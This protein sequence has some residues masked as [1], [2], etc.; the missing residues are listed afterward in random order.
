VRD[1]IDSLCADPPP[2]VP[3]LGPAGA[4]KST[5]TLKALHDRRV[6]ERF[7]PRRYFVRCDG[8]KSREA[9]AAEIARS[10]GIEPAPKVEPAIFRA[11]EAAPTALALDNAETPWDVDTASVE[12]LLAELCAV[13]GLALAASIRGEQRPYG[14][15]WREGIHAGPLT[16]D[17]AR[18]AFLAVAGARHASDPYLSPL[19]E[20]VDRLA[21]A[22]VLLGYQAEAEPDLADL[23][24]RWQERRTEMLQRTGST[25]RLTNVE[26]SLELSIESPRMNEPARRLLSLLALLPAGVARQDLPALLPGGANTGAA[27][28]RGIGLAFDQSGRLRSLSPVRG[29]VRCRRAPSTEDRERAI[30]YYVEL[31]FAGDQ[32]GARPDRAG[33]FHRL[34]GRRAPR[35]VSRIG[36]ATS[37]RSARGSRLHGM[38]RHARPRTAS[39]KFAEALTLYRRIQVPYSFGRVFRRLARLLKGGALQRALVQEAKLA[40]AGD[41]PDLIEELRAEFGDL[42]G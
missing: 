40:W 31:A 7:G 3:I 16:L 17:A 25:E 41:R 32:R 34:A 22:I 6:V 5:I 9:L 36:G 24:R 4:G 18:S 23:W 2:P 26:V 30:A 42:A 28:L 11:L 10:L 20:A 27:A 19:V 33:T 8:A 14:V 13:P 12:A 15:P 1:L 39:K 21:L 37:R 35:R 38:A 29:H